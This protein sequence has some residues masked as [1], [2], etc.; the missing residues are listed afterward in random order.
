MH[1]PTIFLSNKEDLTL[2]EL[3]EVLTQEHD[4]ETVTEMVKTY[5]MESQSLDIQKKSM[6]FLYMH[7]FYKELQ[8][9]INKN[10]ESENASNRLWA[11]VYQINV[12]R[13]FGSY[14]PDQSLQQIK[15]IKTSEPELKCIVEFTRVTIYYDLNQFSKI[16]NFLDIQHELFGAVRDKLLL[17][18]FKIRLNQI[19][20]TYYL[21]R[22]EIIMARKYGYRVLN[23]S[24]SPRTK[25][26]THVRLGLSYTFDTYFQA[27]H[28]IQQALQIGK[29]YNLKNVIQLIEGS[30]IPFLSAHFNKPDGVTTPDKSEQAHLEIAKGNNEKA[31]EI[32]SE[33][34]LDSPFV[35]YYLG[36]A[37]RDKDLLL[38]SYSYFI[39]KRSD[40]FF[41]KLPL[42]ILRNMQ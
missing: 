39:E 18:Y 8:Q 9:L 24:F 35:M 42:N 38:Q 6:E 21:M 25:A 41:S 37:K 34:P 22:N 27:M 23:H 29:K 15:Q 32:L 13:R 12:D 1:L 40:Y 17:S 26:S 19:L 10:K 31:I 30:T 11:K 14:T 2:E 28:H 5:C 20:M 3:M 33:L 7:G 4:N 36:K 16:G